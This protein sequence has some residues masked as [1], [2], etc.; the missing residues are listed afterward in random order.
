M[1]F[2]CPI[3]HHHVTKGNVSVIQREAQYLAWGGQWSEAKTNWPRQRVTY[4]WHHPLSTIVGQCGQI[5]KNVERFSVN[6]NEART[7]HHVQLEDILLSWFQEVTAAGVN[8]NGKVLREEAEGIALTL[9]EQYVIRC[10]GILNIGA[11]PTQTTAS[12]GPEFH[13]ARVLFPLVRTSAF[14]ISNVLILLLIPPPNQSRSSGPLRIGR[15]APRR[16]TQL[17]LRARHLRARH[18]RAWLP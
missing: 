8:V 2:A 9:C 4:V 14:H 6:A 10:T 7:A 3:H 1:Q 5:R 18:L 13:G 11:P 17:H 16:P 12:M 15:W